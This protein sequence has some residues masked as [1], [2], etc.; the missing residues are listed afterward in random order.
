[1][2]TSTRAHILLHVTVDLVIL[3]IR[4]GTLHVLLVERGNQPY[5]GRLALPGGFLHRDET[6]DDAA[7][8]ELAEE[9][10][11]DGC[12]LHLE[13]L[14]SYSDP[15]RDPRGRVVTVSYLAVA[16]SLPTPVAGTDARGAWWEPVAE[17]ISSPSSLAFDHNRILNDGI[18]RAR[19]KLEQTTLATMFCAEP[20]TMGELRQVYEVVWGVPVDPRN[21]SRKVTRTGGFVVPTGAK[22]SLDTG[23]PAALYRRGPATI[24][25]PAMLRAT[26]G[27]GSDSG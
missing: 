15:D 23:R 5:R 11:V 27:H 16:P 2:T 26:I 3:T 12:R 22:R 1:M 4:E 6:L 21:F 7:Q 17:V 10:G 19:S 20:F 18:E 25:Y 13:Q 8:R 24:L 9:T 14:R